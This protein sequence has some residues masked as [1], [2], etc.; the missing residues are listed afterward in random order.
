MQAYYRAAA[1]DSSEEVL[2]I[3]HFPKNFNTLLDNLFNAYGYVP[4]LERFFM[5]YPN[6]LEK[7][8]LAESRLLESDKIDQKIVYFLAFAAAAEKGSAYMMTR[9]LKKYFKSGG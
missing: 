9:Y 1:E 4:S 6:Y 5:F 2:H 3:P 8:I 7:H